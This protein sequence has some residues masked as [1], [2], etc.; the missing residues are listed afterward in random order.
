VGKVVGSGERSG[1]VRQSCV[2]RGAGALPAG[3]A[4]TA[5]SSS[6]LPAI[7]SKISVGSFLEERSGSACGRG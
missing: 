6:K 5:F 3:L 2:P 7:E 1:T 4:A